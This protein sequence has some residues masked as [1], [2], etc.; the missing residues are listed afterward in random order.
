VTAV[1]SSGCGLDNVRS[2]L[3]DPLLKARVEQPAQ[4]RL[5]SAMRHQ[6]ENNRHAA[7]IDADSQQL[8]D[9]GILQSGHVRGLVGDKGEGGG[10]GGVEW[11]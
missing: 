4:H 8:H 11:K 7:R 2:A 9:V 10:R 3:L 1:A 5:E 6:L